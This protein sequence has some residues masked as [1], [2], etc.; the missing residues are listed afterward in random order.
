[1]K[2]FDEIRSILAEHKQELKEKFK[3]EELGIFGS[4]ARSEQRDDSDLDMVIGFE[5]DE[6]MGGFE[7]I[8]RMM[9]VEEFLEKAMEIRV[10]LASKRQDMAD[11]V[12]FDTLPVHW[13][14][15]DLRTFSTTKQM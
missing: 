5:D 4:Y 14:L 8:G 13:N 11:E 9:D 10:H 6:S 7:F 15:F 1:M 12:W 3:V 2:T